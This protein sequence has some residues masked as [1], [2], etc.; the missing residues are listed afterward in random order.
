ML[1]CYRTLA[2]NIV[3]RFGIIGHTYSIACDKARHRCCRIATQQ[4]AKPAAL[5]TLAAQYGRP[6][7]IC[8]CSTTPRDR[9]KLARLRAVAAALAQRHTQGRG[10]ARAALRRPRPARRWRAAACRA[11]RTRPRRRRAEYLGEGRAALL[12][13]ARGAEAETHARSRRGVRTSRRRSK[14]ATTARGARARSSRSAPATRSPRR[15][16]PRRARGCCWHSATRRPPPRGGV[17]LL[18]FADQITI[19][20]LASKLLAVK[21]SQRRGEDVVTSILRACRRLARRA[22]GRRGRRGLCDGHR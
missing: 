6:Q 13:R 18:Q 15:R 21:A 11:C 19:R 10:G 4:I 12:D 7:R 20:P 2:R 22:T 5:R 8:R 14:A 16:W 9:R 3:S 17:D 1:A